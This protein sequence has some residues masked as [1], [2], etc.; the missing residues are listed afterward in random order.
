MSAPDPLPLLKS[1][2]QALVDPEAGERFHRLHTADA[3]LRHEEG[4]RPAS[5]VDVAAFARAHRELNERGGAL[6]PRY[7]APQLTTGAAVGAAGAAAAT[8]AADADAD[9]HADAEAITWFTVVD[10]SRTL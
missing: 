3:V 5:Q 2:L 9:T 1:Y 7:G 4:V 6:L 8:C 10:A